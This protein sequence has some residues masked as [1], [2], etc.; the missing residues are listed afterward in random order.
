MARRLSDFELRNSGETRIWLRRRLAGQSFAGAVADPE[1][2]LQGSDCRIVKSE[3]KIKVGRVALEID[4]VP[5]GVYIKQH[6]AS[7]LYRLASL[8]RLSR[9]LK[10]LKGAAVLEGA[11][12]AAA[13]PLAAVERRRWAMLTKSFFFSEEVAGGARSDLY[14]REQLKPLTGP[15]AFKRRR[16]F[17]TALAGLLRRL[18]AAGVYHGDLKATNIVVQPSGAAER[19]YLL[20]LEGVRACW[21]LSRRRRIKN[22]VQLNRTLGRLLSASEK[23]HVL[24]S[25]LDGVARDGRVRSWARRI[26]SMSEKAER[27]SALKNRRSV[28]REGA[29]E[30]DRPP[31]AESRSASTKDRPQ[32]SAMIVC[33]NEEEMIE[34]CLESVRWCDK[35]VVVDAF[36]NDRTVEICRRY[37]DRVIQRQWKGY[38]DQKVFAHA[39]TTKEWVL[40]VDSDERV[41]P[42]LRE[43]IERAL[44]R[45]RGR[46][47][48]Y[49]MPRLV[50][51][52]G[53]WWWRGGW[54][55]DYRLRLFRRERASWAGEEP[56]DK[57]VVDGEVR[58]LRAPIYHFSYRNMDDHMQ[59]IN[60]FTT[61]A[62]QQLYDKGAPWRW[63]DALGRP[64]VRFFRSY[65]LERG[66]LEGFA[67][68]Y[69]AVTAAMYVFLKYAKLWELKSGGEQKGDSG[70]G[71]PPA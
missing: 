40:V 68:F 27:R 33:F 49:A 9:A 65:V 61:I 22:F 45:D 44:A 14:W 8:V 52:L 54:Y 55:P 23:L 29:G 6:N 24:R 53:R 7:P 42:E 10:A 28:A 37:T 5:T 62:A 20:D 41:S 1:R 11:G 66:F 31:T 21:Y 18:H 16:Q 38:R 64:A 15:A 3:P 19:F 48:G 56:H 67:G 46:Y 60:R 35:I 32:I 13:T 17:L 71:G 25:Y 50:F 30:R 39:Q 12:V 34:P 2:L 51:Y 43:E 47:A 59:R 4:G 26:L 70:E 57:V 36:S 69:V 63:I 58:R